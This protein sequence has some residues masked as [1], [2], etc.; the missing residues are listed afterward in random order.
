MVLGRNECR[1]GPDDV[2]HTR[3]TTLAFLLLMLSPFDIFDRDYALI[4][5][6]LCKSNILWNILIILGRNVG[7]CR[8][9]RRRKTS[10]PLCNLNTFSNTLMILDR[11]V[12]QDKMTCH[13]QD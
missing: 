9:Q 5:C 11:N 12:G 3:M 10:C 6:P 13:I 2:L 7:S 8:R 4:S 1:T